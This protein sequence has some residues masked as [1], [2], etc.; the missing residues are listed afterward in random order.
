[1]AFIGTKGLRNHEKTHLIP[2]PIFRETTNENEDAVGEDDPHHL[3]GEDQSTELPH[4]VALPPPVLGGL[5][6]EP[7][8]ENYLFLD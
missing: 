7:E 3:T 5:E 6:I 8:D 2:M 1:M 4:R